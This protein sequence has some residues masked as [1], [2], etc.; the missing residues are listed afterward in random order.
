MYKDF[1]FQR[2]NKIIVKEKGKSTL[3]KTDQITHITCIGSLSKVHTINNKSYSITKLLKQFDS[4]LSNFG[5]MRAN[6]NTI[7]NMMHVNEIYGFQKR[8]LLLT[9]NIEIKISR[10]KMYLFRD[11]L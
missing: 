7:V 4:E 5:F 8:K 2:D 10:R 1:R 6:H 9:N 11:F 3:I